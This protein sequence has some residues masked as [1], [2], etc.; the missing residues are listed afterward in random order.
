MAKESKEERELRAA[1]KKEA[2]AIQPIKT[3]AD[4]FKAIRKREKENGKE[5][6]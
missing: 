2:G 4:I 1:L 5:D 6:S 3:L